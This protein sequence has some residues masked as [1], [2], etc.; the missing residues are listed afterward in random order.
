MTTGQG[1]FVSIPVTLHQQ[2]AVTN[3]D[4]DSPQI[5]DIFVCFENPILHMLLLIGWYYSLSSIAANPFPGLCCVACS[6]GI[7]QTDDPVAQSAW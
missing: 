4:T 7:Q 3:K 1:I 2:L 6:P 5:A